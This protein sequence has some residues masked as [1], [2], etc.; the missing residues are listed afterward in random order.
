[1][2]ILVK[3]PDLRH[4][5]A[6]ILRFCFLFGLLCVPS[7]FGAAPIKFDY[8]KIGSKVHSNVTVIGWNETDL[9]FTSSR[10]INNV[11]IRLLELKLQKKFNYNPKVAAEIERQQ[12]KDDQRFQQEYASNL[13][14]RAQQAAAAAA[15]AARKVTSTSEDS[16]GDP[17]SDKSLLGK[18][19]PA[20]QVEKWL[21][22]KPETDGKF[23]L[24]TVWAPWSIPCRK[25]IP[26]LN[27]LQKKFAEKLT[28]IALSS[29]PEKEIEQMDGPAIEF[30]SAIDTKSRLTAAA[31]ITSIPCALLL[32]HK[33][34]VRYTGHPGFLDEKK[35]QSLLAA[36]ATEQ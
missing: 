30:A 21:S 31:G 34:I 5:H 27:A 19:A 6:V 20:L 1:L 36:A 29:E 9:Y 2:S 3:W 16:L 13:V 23:I 15:D 22:E 28:V 17:I 18:P 33:R 4:I 25:A 10:G 12:E 7:S 11:K 35:L 26:E 14:A 32:D 8:L 24:L